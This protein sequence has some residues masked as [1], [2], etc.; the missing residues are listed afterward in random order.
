M[1]HHQAMHEFGR[2]TPWSQPS[3][4]AILYIRYEMHIAHARVEFK[5]D[6]I[7]HNER[8]STKTT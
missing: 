5:K 6:A 7:H 3:R 8:M 1:C 2:T 4:S